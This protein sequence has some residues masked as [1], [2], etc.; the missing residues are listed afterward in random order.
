MQSTKTAAFEPT[1][2]LAATLSDAQERSAATFARAYDVLTKTA[3]AIWESEPELLKLESDQLLKTFAPLKT[4]ENPVAGLSAYCEQLHDN[5]ERMIARMRHINDL[6]WG[7]GWQI[8]AIYADGLQ[9]MWKQAQ[10]Q[11]Q[12]PAEPARGKPA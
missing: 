10:A 12:P 11:V 7:C 6:A 4:G 1:A 8:A 5:S 9:D 3:Q 2:A